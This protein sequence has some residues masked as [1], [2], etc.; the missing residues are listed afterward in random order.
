[1][2]RGGH[3]GGLRNYRGAASG[4]RPESAALA[5]TAVPAWPPA[6]SLAGAAVKSILCYVIAESCRDFGV[7]STW[8][9]KSL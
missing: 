6:P 1:M 3:V 7:F 8:A 2:A 5:I 4:I 9:S